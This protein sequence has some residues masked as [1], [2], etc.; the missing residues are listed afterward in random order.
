[1]HLNLDMKHRKEVKF[2]EE[3]SIS[4]NEQILPFCIVVRFFNVNIENLRQRS[5]AETDDLLG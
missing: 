1:M 5:R 4:L 3:K 2:N